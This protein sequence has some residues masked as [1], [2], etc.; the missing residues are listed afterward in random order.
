MG[1][2][3][4]A[5]KDEATAEKGGAVVEIDLNEKF[6]KIEFEKTEIPDVDATFDKAGGI[7]TEILS[8]NDKLTDG[9]QTVIK[10]ETDAEDDAEDDKALKKS[11]SQTLSKR[12]QDALLGARDSMEDA[13][14]DNVA[15]IRKKFEESKDASQK[16]AQAKGDD[17]K[18]LQEA[19]K[20]K[21]KE[22]AALVAAAMPKMATLLP[23]VE[24]TAITFPKGINLEKLTPDSKKAMEMVKKFI[25]VLTQIGKESFDALKIKMKDMADDLKAL[26]P[27]M[28]EFFTA[29]MK[30][31]DM[32]AKGKWM[33]EKAVDYKNKMAS[34]TTLSKNIQIY[35]TKMAAKLTAIIKIIADAFK[36]AI[37]VALTYAPGVMAAVKGA[38]ESAKASAAS[39]ADAHKDEIDAA[40]VS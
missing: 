19:A 33:K 13:M 9:V 40:K 35:S 28:Q 2:G 18:P 3:A 30:D 24:G 39:I 12:I 22:A 10:S 29:A 37:E 25:A 26:P 36:S 27:K 7:V 16:A 32:M 5:K 17:A 4:S 11:A 15:E 21:V 6:E 23:G 14:P 38:V 34:N 20:A 31:M 1:C 8:M